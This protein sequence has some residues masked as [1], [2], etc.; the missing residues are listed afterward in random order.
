MFD[1][2]P[3]TEIVLETSA[4]NT[5]STSPIK[6]LTTTST[7]PCISNTYTRLTNDKD[8]NDD[9]D[10]VVPIPSGIFDTE[11]ISETVLETSATNV[12][13]D[14]PIKVEPKTKPTPTLV[15]NT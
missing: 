10:E 3:T 12:T 4:A 9:N 5:F 13:R 1:T 14:S 8:N 15:S 7:P 6:K 11:P 2:N